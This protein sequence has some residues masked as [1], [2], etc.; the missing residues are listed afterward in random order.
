MIK[1][2]REKNAKRGEQC[3]CHAC[4][5]DEKRKSNYK[6]P[7]AKVMHAAMHP[8]IYCRGLSVCETLHAE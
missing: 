7:I 4:I 6:H 8:A 2:H 1:N 3:V 5:Y